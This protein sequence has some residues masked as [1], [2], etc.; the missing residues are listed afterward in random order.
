MDGLIGHLKKEIGLCKE[1]I[2]VLQRETESIVARDYTA[3]YET[4]GEKE[5]LVRKVNATAGERARHI[6]EARM[7]LGI[8][9]GSGPA[10]DAVVERGGERGAELDGCLRTLASLAASIKELND[11][12]SLAI[13]SSLDNVK[14]TLGFLGNF[15]QPSAY[16]PGGGAEGLSFKGSRLN[17]GA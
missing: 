1:L 5:E 17:K 10:I 6:D 11:L 9:A 15:L 16:K 8:P 12:N 14:K 4:A 13:R 2:A 3:L 7:E